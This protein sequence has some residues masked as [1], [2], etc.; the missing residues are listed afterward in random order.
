[1]IGFLAAS[2]RFTPPVM[3][4]APQWAALATVPLLSFAAA[5]AWLSR[6]ERMLRVSAEGQEA[7]VRD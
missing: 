7:L 4:T 5:A 6:H 1:L 2:S 3:L